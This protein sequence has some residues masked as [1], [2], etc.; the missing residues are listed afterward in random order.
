MYLHI[1]QDV[2]VR[3][4]EIVGIFNLENTTVSRNTK[5]FLAQAEKGGEVV[6]A[7][8]ELPKTFVVCAPAER[9]TPHEQHEQTVYISQL[10]PATLYKRAGR[11][12]GV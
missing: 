11:R 1:G 9:R 10:A 5:D 3:K 4:R 2:M 8:M 7:T 6:Y 12:E